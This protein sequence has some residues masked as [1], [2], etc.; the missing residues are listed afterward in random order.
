LLKLTFNLPPSKQ[1][2]EDVRSA[3]DELTESLL[4]SSRLAEKFVTILNDNFLAID[5]TDRKDLITASAGIDIAL[6]K[7]NVALHKMRTHHY[8]IISFNRE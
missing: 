1:E 5:S 4:N 6:W 3:M 7:M 2:I 8:R